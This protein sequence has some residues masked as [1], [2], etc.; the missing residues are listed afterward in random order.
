MSVQQV[1]EPPVP[2]AARPWLGAAAF[3]A[4]GLAF[5]AV[6]G[7]GIL[8]SP[9]DAYLEVQS[10]YVYQLGPLVAFALSLLAVWRTSG[11]DRLGWVA[12]AILLATWSAGDL[13]YTY[14]NE[15]FG[16]D[17]P[18]P[19]VADIFYYIGYVAFLIGLGF[20]AMPRSRVRDYRWLI[21]AAVILAAG[22]AVSWTF[23]L[24]PIVQDSGYAPRDAAV[25]LGYPVFD[26]G[27]VA[28]AFIALYAASARASARVFLLMLSA[29]S[30]GIGDSA[31]TYLVSTVG[32]ESIAHPTD[33]AYLLSY[34][35]IGACA[36]LP[37]QKESSA[38]PRSHSV[39]GLLLPYVVA[40]AL[41]TL[42]SVR[43]ALGEVEVPL[44]LGTAAVIGLVGARQFLTLLDNLGLYR[45]LDSESRARRSLLDMV[46]RAQ[47]DERHR[48]AFDLHDGPVQALS[49][50]GTRVA[51][52]RKFA[53]R[54]ET[55]RADKILS[56]V[57]TSLG[58]EVQSL[59]NFMMDLRP[60][61]LAERGIVEAI[62]D[63]AAGIR[64]TS[65]QVYVSG[66]IEVRPHG[67]V[68]SMLY[69]IAQEALSN[70]RKHARAAH[71]TIDVKGTHDEITMSVRDDGIGFVVPELSDLAASQHFGMLGIAERAAL[72]GGECIWTSEP[73]QGAVLDV[74]VPIDEPAEEQR[75][76][77]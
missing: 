41:I 56:E 5:I 21:D 40:A 47:E 22:A 67:A 58:A 77:A 26:F 66:S 33:V 43:L 2:T 51:A 54:A 75:S 31:Y 60:P 72:L 68:E 25:A 15:R 27:L 35:L 32:Y 10:L 62:R 57:E 48:L 49:F 74:R 64:D 70:T 9:G 28:V 17:P 12:L 73:G 65:L 71:A 39:Y 7:A 18:F 1:F 11:R 13:T 4:A 30:L 36:L 42:T 45:A 69:R 19:G 63:L 16:E 76:A 29:L 38:S 14:Y 46:V 44:M 23:I 8:M 20:L 52:A 50:L 3:L 6:Y 61:S 37:E 24:Q 34:V 55:A 59:R 53:A